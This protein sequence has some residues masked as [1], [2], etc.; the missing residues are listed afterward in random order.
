MERI[1]VNGDYVPDQNG[2]LRGV[3]GAQEALARALFRLTARRGALPF[4]P[5]LGSELF[6]LCRERES[7][8]PAL[9]ARYV[10]QALRDEPELEVQSVTLTREGEAG[11]LTVELKWREEQMRAV[12][13]IGEGEVRELE[14]R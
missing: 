3:S 1:L 8:R 10:E 14:H 7:A 5:E 2:G 4:L 12:L 6:Q 11:R 13:T 9:A